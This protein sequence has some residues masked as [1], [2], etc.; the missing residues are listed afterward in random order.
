MKTFKLGEKEINFSNTW[1]DLTMKQWIEFYK[2]N[3][4]KD[5]LV[6][7]FY[8]LSVLEI[9][10]NVYPGELDDLSLPKYNEL[11]ND[12]TFMLETPKLKDPEPIKIGDTTYTIKTD[13]NNITT[14]EYI[15]IKTLQ[16]R[17]T[18]NLDGIPYLLAVIIRPSKMVKNEETGEE[19]WVQ[20]KFDTL[21]LDFRADLIYNNFKAVDVMRG[22]SFFLNGKN[23]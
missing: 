19:V 7:E 4:K 14:G 18:N 6:E 8:L 1:E 11:L 17:Y 9:L 5:S 3:E 13:L 10:C 15:S 12:L 16:S 21:N 22:V 20:E 23:D 2:L